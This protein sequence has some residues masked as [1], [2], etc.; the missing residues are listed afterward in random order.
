MPLQPRPNKPQ[1]I[2]KRKPANRSHFGFLALTALCAVAT[3]IGAGPDPALAIVTK[4][5]PSP[6]PYGAGPT[7]A[8]TPSASA[9]I[10]PV[11]SSVFFVL[12]GTVSSR[13]E[14][15]AT[16]GAHLRDAIVVGGNTLAAAG[17]PIELSI[18]DVR[19]ALMGNVDGWVEVE[20]RP[21][22]LADGQM[23]PLRLPRSHIDRYVSV[24]QASTQETTDTI[25]DIFVPYHMLYHALRKG[26]DITLKP[27]TVLRAR[28]GAAISI[29]GKAVVLSTPQ[30][31]ASSIDKP[32]AAFSPAPIFTPRGFVAPTPKPSPSPIPTT[33]P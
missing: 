18:I 7:T 17:A 15:G 8:A 19:R 21:L 23:L 5:T 11:D 16:V 4:P 25:G 20:L 29:A 13:G 3:A 9:K 33:T 24:G 14:R 2:V 1:P 28:T 10:L 32:Y 12:D 6:A 30:P 22:K 27:G 26:S 31:F